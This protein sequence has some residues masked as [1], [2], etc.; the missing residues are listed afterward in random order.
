MQYSRAM[1]LAMMTMKT[2]VHGFPISVDF[3]WVW[4]SALRPFGPLWSSATKKMAPLRIINATDALLQNT[5]KIV[6]LGL[7]IFKFLTTNPESLLGLDPENF[8]PHSFRGGG[9]TYAFQAGV[10]EHLPNSW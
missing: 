7:L 9:A 2:Q 4:G 6:C 5:T 8:L 10:P 1:P 3:L